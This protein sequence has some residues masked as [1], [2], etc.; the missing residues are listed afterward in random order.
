[1]QYVARDALP[2][3]VSVSRTI[4]VLVAEITQSHMT[5]L[6]ARQPQSDP[7]TRV[8]RNQLTLNYIAFLYL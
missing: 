3:I 4:L 6:S 8:L 7:Q 5:D 1:M 2:L